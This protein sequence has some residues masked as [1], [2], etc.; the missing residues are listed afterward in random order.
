M[1]RK[2]VKKDIGSER[3]KRGEKKKKDMVKK[4]PRMLLFDDYIVADNERVGLK[5]MSRKL[6]KRL[7]SA[8]G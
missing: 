4:M 5:I 1:S 8:K 6:V 7:M 3:L 2:L